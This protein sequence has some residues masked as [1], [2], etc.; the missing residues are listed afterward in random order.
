MSLYYLYTL[1]LSYC[2]PLLL[3]FLERH[4]QRMSKLV[5]QTQFIDYTF[6]CMRLG[7]KTSPNST[8]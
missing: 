8:A 7:E 6:Q 2:I 1:S 4:Y 5:Q 3:L